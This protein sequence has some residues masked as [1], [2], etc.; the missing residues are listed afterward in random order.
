MC[1]ASK[2]PMNKKKLL[3]TGILIYANESKLNLNDF[4]SILPSG[5]YT[6]S[7]ESKIEKF[8]LEYDKEYLKITFGDGNTGPRSPFVFNTETQLEEENPRNKNQIEPKENFAIVDF[9]TSFLWISNSKKRNAII[10]FFKEK[11]NKL[12]FVV[13][14]IYDETLFIETLKKIDNISVSVVPNLWSNTN[15]LNKVMCEEIN[16]YGASRATIKFDY[17]HTLTTEFIKEKIRNILNNKNSLKQIVISGRDERNLGLILNTEGFARKIEIDASIDEDE[18]FIH[19]S[20]FNN[21]ISKIDNEK[22]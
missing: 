6:N 1:N 9:S 5:I 8:N 12:N 18:M 7:N 11:F 4:K 19:D 13:K 2:K 15:I 14:E 16:G 10:T 21:L 22:L 17:E 20:V 3:F